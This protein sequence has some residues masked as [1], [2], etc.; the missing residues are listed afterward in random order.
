MASYMYEHNSNTPPFLNTNQPLYGPGS[1]A[2]N[3]TGKAMDFAASRYMDDWRYNNPHNSCCMAPQYQ[4]PY[5]YDD[6]NR[7]A[8]TTYPQ[9]YIP[10]Q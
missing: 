2:M 4:M 3:N 9:W 7:A 8:Y 6:Y 10:N 1:Y 5:G